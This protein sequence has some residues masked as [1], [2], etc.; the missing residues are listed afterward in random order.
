MNKRFSRHPI[1]TGTLILS[2]TNITTRIIGFLYRV[3]LSRMFDAEGMGIIQLSGPISAMVYSLS[4]AGMQTAISKCVSSIS[5]TEKKKRNKYLYCGLFCALFT[6]CLCSFFVYRYAVFFAVRFL[7]E[8]RTAPIL[9][10]LALS[11]P[12]SAIHACINGYYIGKQKTLLPAASQLTEQLVRVATVYLCCTS[13]LS[14]GDTPQLAFT[15]WGVCIGEAAALCVV[16]VGFYFGKHKNRQ[17]LKLIPHPLNETRIL[18]SLFIISAPLSAN[19]LAVNFLQSIEAVRIPL[20]LQVYGL[21]DSAALS[22]YGILTGMAFPVVFF[23][24]AFTGALSAMLLPTVSEAHSKNDHKRIRSITTQATFLVVFAGL[25]FGLLIFMFSDF[26]GSVIFHEPLAASYIRALSMLCPIM[27]L[28]S[29]FTGILQGLGKVMTIFFIN[30]TGLLLRLFF[31]FV[32]IPK[33]GITGYLIGLLVSQLY[34][35]SMYLYQCY[36]L[37][38]EPIST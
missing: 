27:Y 37:K 30:V 33:Y 2:A 23:P 18:R 26:I 10:I 28:N 32:Y 5:D 4:A 24:G 36:K 7:S 11:Y 15:A 3:Y 8:S 1:L 38:Q 35:T 20:M 14:T 17:G 9:R 13:F 21:S 25:L 19:R 16:F 6:A 22:T 34:S 29:V 12:L 31:V